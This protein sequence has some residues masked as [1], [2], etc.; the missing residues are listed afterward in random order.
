MN[1]TFS[2]ESDRSKVG[3]Q[4]V[5]ILLNRGDQW[6]YLAVGLVTLFIAVGCAGNVMVL[7]AVR[8]VK[9]LQTV[10]NIFVL[11]LS[12]CDLLI[13]VCVLPF[14]IYTY[15]AD[16]WFTATYLCKFIGFL[17]YTLSGTTIITITMIAYNRYKLV[18]DPGGYMTLYTN[19]N[20]TFM[21]VVAWFVP[22]IC[23]IPAL[24]GLWGNFGYVAMMVSCNLLLDHKNQLFKI[25]LMIIRAVIPCGLIVY[26]YVRIY[27]TTLRSHHRLTQ[28]S[29]QL[30]S[31]DIHNQRREMRMT[32]MM[33]M[34]FIVFALSYFPCTI[35]GIV[36][37]NTVLSKQFHMFCQLS[38]FIGSA[39]NP[40][41]YGLMNLQFRNAY[42]RICCWTKRSETELKSKTLNRI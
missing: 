23:L 19:R 25:F 38:L 10:S 33:L 30:S 26:Y 27:H 8:K 31:L 39:I 15:I 21:L 35:T 34:I 37:W 6:V 42:I 18:L 40:L 24:T 29:R 1:E 41:I 17:G 22:V 11:N 20:I 12:V 14:N 5:K 7:L 9:K 36:D 4:T 32:R 3:V 2:N 16:G 28:N 13:V